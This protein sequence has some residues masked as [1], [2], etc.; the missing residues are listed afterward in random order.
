L[1]LTALQLGFGI[2]FGVGFTIGFGV[3]VVLCVGV[4]V[5]WI[6][7]GDDS[8]KSAWVTVGLTWSSTWPAF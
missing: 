5:I 2:G 3:G 7:V 6:V 4:G 8:A 1:L